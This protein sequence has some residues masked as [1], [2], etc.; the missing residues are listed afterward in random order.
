MERGKYI[1]IDEDKFNC[2]TTIHK[3]IKDVQKAIIENHKLGEAVEID[4]INK[5][6]KATK[7]KDMTLNNI[8]GNLWTQIRNS[9]HLERTN[10][11]NKP[12]CLIYDG[13]T[14]PITVR[15]TL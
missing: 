10:D 6:L 7:Y 15:F 1:V 9:S 4:W 13:T 11:L 2:T 3:L 5:Q 8:R 12:H 14:T